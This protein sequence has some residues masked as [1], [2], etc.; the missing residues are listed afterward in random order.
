MKIQIFFILILVLSSCVSSHKQ[1][2]KNFKIHPLSIVQGVTTSDRTIMSII[3]KKTDNELLY[4]YKE[5]VDG[6]PEKAVMTFIKKLS[7]DQKYKIEHLQLDGLDPLK[8]YRLVVKND[9]GT[10]IDER[11]FKSLDQNKKNIRIGVASCMDDKIESMEMWSSYLN[12]FADVNFFIGDN[13]YADIIEGERKTADP[14]Q[15]WKRYIQTFSSLYFYHSSHLTPTYFLWDDHDY[16]QNDGN[17]DYEYKK[18]SLE[19]FS[20]FSPRENIENFYKTTFGA[21]SILNAFGQKF[22]FIDARSFRDKDKD[23]LQ[24]GKEQSKF[25]F[26]EIKKSKNMVWLIQGDQF[27]GGY[28]RFESFENDHPKDFKNFLKNLK[29]INKKV[30]F[31]SGD[32]HLTEIMKIKKEEVGFDT[33]EITSSGIHAVVFPGA[34]KKEPNPRQ[35]IGKSGVFNF[36]IIDVSLGDDGK[37]DYQVTSYGAKNWTH[38]TRELEL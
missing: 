6:S 10:L 17:S 14:E 24:W 26:D 31:V 37:Q 30:L 33:Y 2:N 22:I 36:T 23:G 16:G 35:V 38:Y 34:F 9:K 32:R 4:F 19:I 29:K 1:Q 15:L 12:K 25:V 13:V 21:G 3:S 8:T 28:H 27:F 7:P 20:L 18:E 5:D 11:T